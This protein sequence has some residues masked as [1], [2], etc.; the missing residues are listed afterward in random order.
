MLGYGFCFALYF[1]DECGFEFRMI[2]KVL[3]KYM[4]IGLL[5]VILV[6]N[7]ICIFSYVLWFFKDI[8]F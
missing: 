6:M 5:F 1:K 7:F 4:L 3:C 2:F 8:I